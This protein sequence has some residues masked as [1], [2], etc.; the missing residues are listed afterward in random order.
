MQLTT[1]GRNARKSRRNFI[2]LSH[3]GRLHALITIVNEWAG[4]FRYLLLGR[5]ISKRP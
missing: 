5:Q 3:V 2:S 4:L 1:E